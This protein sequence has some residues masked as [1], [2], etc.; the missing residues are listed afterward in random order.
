[1][2]WIQE[3]SLL[4]LDSQDLKL[5]AECTPLWKD[6]PPENAQN[7]YIL[8]HRCFTYALSIQPSNQALLN[9]RYAIEKKLRQESLI[10]FNEDPQEKEE[11]NMFFEHNDFES[12]SADFLCPADEDFQI[13][14]Y[15]EDDEI[16]TPAYELSEILDHMDIVL[17]PLPD[18]VDK[19]VVLQKLKDSGIES[20]ME[21][22][23]YSP[24]ELAEKCSLTELEVDALA[25]KYRHLRTREWMRRRR[26]AR[27]RGR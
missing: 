15:A 22:S 14:G 4:H 1:M 25:Q 17:P 21:L 10:P 13:A 5:L 9:K 12:D 2:E 6:I 24:E 19:D 26:E 23:L 8:M 11:F 18:D 7:P 3:R 16:L 27:Q 20:S